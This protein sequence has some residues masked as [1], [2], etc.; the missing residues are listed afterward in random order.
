M[1]VDRN[2][3]VDFYWFSGTG[4]TLSIIRKMKDV[5][6]KSGITVSLKKMEDSD[7]AAVDCNHTIG[8]GFPVAM[9]GTYPLVW[10][11]IKGLESCRETDVFMVDTLMLYSGGIVGPA[12]RILRKKGF[13]LA[14]AREIR[15]PDNLFVHTPGGSEKD[16]EKSLKGLSEAEKFAGDLINGT[17]RWRDIPVYSSAM[18]VFSRLSLTW[19][20]FRRIFPLKV[21]HDI[22]TRCG[23]CEKLCPVN[24]WTLDS[25]IN[26]MEW[27]EECIFCLRCFS[28][29]PVNA[30]H[31]GS[32][33]NLQYSP[34]S[35]SDFL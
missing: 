10:D 20:F 4:N 32:R 24:N 18:S 2:R 12:G 23:L 34:L 8:L 25:S 9:Q 29:C 15:M 6:E 31:Y 33:N 5:F 35:A 14:G 16:T 26:K 22:C 27:G 11:F 21:D 7:P 28:Y 30:I 13:R 17:S 3:P 19:K 1:G